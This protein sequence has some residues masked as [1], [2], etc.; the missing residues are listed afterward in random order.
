MS[1]V[2][3]AWAW[4]IAWA[5]N[6]GTFPRRGWRSAKPATFEAKAPWE[7]PVSLLEGFDT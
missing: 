3:S 5:L 1:F 6:V 7:N 2:G 4:F